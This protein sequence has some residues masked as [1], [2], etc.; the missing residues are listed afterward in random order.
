MTGSYHSVADERDDSLRARLS[1]PALIAAAA[2]SNAGNNLT[3][4]A[5]PWFVLVTTGSAA[6]TGLVAF[7]GLLPIAIAGIAGGALVDR[8]G[9]KR[10]SVISDVAS[11]VTVAMVPTLYLLDALQ[12]WHLLALAFLG[13]LLDVPGAAARQTMIPRLAHRVGMPLERINSAYQIAVFG[14]VVAGPL[15]AGVLIV[16]VGAANVLYVNTVTF[17]LSAVAVALGVDLVRSPVTRWDEAAGVAR[18]WSVS[19]AFDGLRFLRRERVLFN[20]CIVSGFAN[21]LFAPLFAVIFPVYVKSVFDD[22]RAL[23]F[24]VASFGIGSVA[25]T[26]WYGAF[27]PKMRRYPIFVVG[28]TLASAG[29]WVMPS[30]THMA[31][32]VAAGFVVGMALGPLNAVVMVVL[33]ERVPEQMLGRVMGSLFAVSQIAAPAGVLVAGF[34][35]DGFSVRSVMVAVAVGFSVIVTW[36]IV[37]PVFRQ[38]ERPVDAAALVAEA[39]T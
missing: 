30:A 34:A 20:I 24:L 13:A 39:R 11:G 3:A 31:A 19:E 5:I 12:F 35:I 29:L 28:A 26:V 2:V 17:A 6:R 16:S 23:G 1:I 38:M 22:P 4:I 8:I 25:A 7:A 15:L 18:R 32:S 10:A 36:I 37:A 14:A 9:A 21:F 33:Q 27:G